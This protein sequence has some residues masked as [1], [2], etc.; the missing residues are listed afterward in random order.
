MKIENFRNKYRIRK[1]VE[2]K[3]YSLILD[4]KPTQ[5]EAL[6]LMSEM[7]ND[8]SKY[9]SKISFESA[10]LKYIGSKVNI[11]SP[12]T[13]R[14]YRVHLDK[15]LSENFKAMNIN[16]ITQLDIQTELNLFA[17]D[18]KSKTVRNLSGFISSVLKV[19]RPNF[20]YNVTLPQREAS[21]PYIP[22]DEDVKKVLEFV[23]GTE[24]EVPFK[25]AVFALRRSEICALTKKDIKG[26]ILTINKA[27][28]P[29][30]QGEFIIKPMAKTDA[31]N[32]QIWI[33]DELADQIKKMDEVFPYPPDRLTK[34]LK[35]VTRQLEIPEFSIHKLRHY[36]CSMAHAMGIPDVYIM[37]QGGWKS[38]YVMKRVYRH[39]Q[40]EKSKMVT[41]EIGEKIEQLF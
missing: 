30:D 39:A 20:N 31:G 19:F 15:Q 7:V 32:R 13:I 38:D 16:D 36:Y 18:H 37:D 1:T 24:Y 26:N 29:N 4:Y 34:R 25:L 33:P 28:V 11:L 35:S 22:S 14:S 21:E 12:S 2:G 23:K 3:T 8:T 27:K 10:A 5:K 6:L 40:E 9:G 41:R 17:A